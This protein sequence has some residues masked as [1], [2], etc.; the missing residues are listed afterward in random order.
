MLDSFILKIYYH[1]YWLWKSKCYT[2]VNKLIKK[3]TLIGETRMERQMRDVELP[4]V[5]KKCYLV[6]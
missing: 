3:Y 4:K 2:C 5:R 6:A 1:F